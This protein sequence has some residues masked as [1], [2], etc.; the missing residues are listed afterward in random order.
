MAFFLHELIPLEFAQRYPGVWKR[1]ETVDEKDLVYIPNRLYSVEIKS[2]SSAGQIYG[3]RSYAQVTS[4]DK[5]EKAGY[6]IA[7]NF[8]KFGLGR[9]PALTSIRFG[10]LDHTDWIGQKAASGQQAHIDTNAAQYKL[11]KLPLDQ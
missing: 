4:S 3:N 1:E 9:L 8:E 11:L 5:K 6:Y 10:W 7:I 2:S